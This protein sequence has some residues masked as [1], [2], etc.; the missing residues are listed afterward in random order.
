MG[1]VQNPTPAQQL[2]AQ[3]EHPS[4]NSIWIRALEVFGD[5]TKARSWMNSPRDVFGGRSPQD[6]VDT[7]NAAEQRRVLE[8]LL[9]IDY[10]VF[11]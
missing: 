10:G 4:A 3:L 11:S 8:V 6:M 9:R 1:T 5:D 2:A 7:G